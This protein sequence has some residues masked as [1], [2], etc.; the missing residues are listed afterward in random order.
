MAQWAG[1]CVDGETRRPRSTTNLQ[2][3]GRPREEFLGLCVKAWTG[4]REDGENR[5][6][7]WL[8]SGAYAAKKATL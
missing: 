4:R 2:T 3:L 5:R 6:R 1:E 8:A 7:C